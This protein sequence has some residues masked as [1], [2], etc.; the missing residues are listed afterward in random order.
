MDYWEMQVRELE[1]RLGYWL[2]ICHGILFTLNISVLKVNKIQCDGQEKFD[3]NQKQI[4]KYFL[5]L[6]ITQALSHHRLLG[7]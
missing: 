1:Q 4:R 7:Q 3:D 6:F 5:I 2:R